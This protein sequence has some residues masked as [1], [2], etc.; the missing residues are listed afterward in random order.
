M[1]S[2]RDEVVTKHVAETIIVKDDLADI[3]VIFLL[4]RISFNED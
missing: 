4:R 2:V 1:K 3:I